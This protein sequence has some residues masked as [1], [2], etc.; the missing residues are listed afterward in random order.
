MKVQQREKELNG[1]ESKES[2]MKERIWDRK[3]DS[4]RCVC[5]VDLN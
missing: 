1:R 5:V 3:I 2:K 4:E